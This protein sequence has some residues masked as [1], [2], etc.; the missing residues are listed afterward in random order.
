[1]KP[2]VVREGNIIK[3][4]F[5]SRDRTSLEDRTLNAATEWL[6]SE[7]NEPVTLVRLRSLAKKELKRPRSS[8][9]K[10]WSECFLKETDGYP[11]LCTGC[12]ADDC[13]RLWK[14][15]KK[16]CPDCSHKKLNELDMLRTI[17]S[18]AIKLELSSHDVIEA[19]ERLGYG[20]LIAEARRGK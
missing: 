18:M 9:H 19:M 20:E 7:L 1:M 17:A 6:L 8:V 16:C 11:E 14:E 13:S 5:P 4:P 3:I 10:K 2:R 15:Q 12:G